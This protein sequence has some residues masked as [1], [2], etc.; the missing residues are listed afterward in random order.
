VADSPDD[1]RLGTPGHHNMDASAIVYI[2]DDDP[3][4]RATLEQLAAS[5]GL[6]SRACATVVDFMQLFDSRQHGCLLLDVRL[7]GV[8]G[9]DL[10]DKLTTDGVQLPVIILTGYADVGMA[11]RALKAGAFDFIE[12]PFTGQSLLDSIQRAIAADA[13]Q[14]RQLA[15]RTD[16]TRRRATLTPREQEVIKLLLDGKNVRQIAAQLR[17]SHKTVQLHRRR[18]VEKMGVDSVANLLR[19]AAAIGYF[20]PLESTSAPSGHAVPAAKWIHTRS[21]PLP[22][23]SVWPP[24][25]GASETEPPILFPPPDEPRALPPGSG[26]PAG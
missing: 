6:Q 17:L 19:L 10:L 14:R 8:G 4:A 26:P 11:V 18:I 1:D 24:I 25:E 2:V 9:L 16:F 15:R 20:Q 5:A 3:A 22:D 23:A 13:E 12:K 21:R 7:P